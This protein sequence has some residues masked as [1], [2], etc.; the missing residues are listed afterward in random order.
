MP[1]HV[2]PL[3][4]G[5]VG[6]RHWPACK[7]GFLDECITLTAE[8]RDPIGDMNQDSGRIMGAGR[9]TLECADLEPT[10]SNAH[11]SLV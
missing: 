10:C 5:I 4:Y 6:Q 9:L 8:K 7:T 1:R 2:L 3:L 11:A